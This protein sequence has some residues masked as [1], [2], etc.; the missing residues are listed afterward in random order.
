MW[1]LYF[2][3]EMKT[4]EVQYKGKTVKVNESY[5]IQ[6]LKTELH[7]LEE[8][9]LHA[10]VK[11]MLATKLHCMTSQE[12]CGS[13][14]WE[15]ADKKFPIR[16]H[17][18]GQPARNLIYNYIPRQNYNN[19]V[20]EEKDF[21]LETSSGGRLYIKPDVCIFHFKPLSIFEIIVTS[22]P[23]I[24]KLI[25]MIEAPVNVVFIYAEDVIGDLSRKF[26]IHTDW[27]NLFKCFTGWRAEDSLI[28]KVSRTVD[29]LIADKFPANGQ[30]ILGKKIKKNGD[31]YK[32]LIKTDRRDWHL[33][34]GSKAGKP[35]SPLNAL[36]KCYAEKMDASTEEVHYDDNAMT[37]KFVAR[38]TYHNY[39]D[40]FH[41]GT[42][43]EAFQGE[44]TLFTNREAGIVNKTNYRNIK[45]G[46]E[47]QF[48]CGTGN[49][50]KNGY[51][52]Y[53]AN[54]HVSEKNNF[55]KIRENYFNK[56]WVLE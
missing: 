18:S 28:T 42:I 22:K 48:I 12:L 43:L 38:D 25:A 31:L 14:T 56:V 5:P 32:L 34:P 26:N 10:Q 35:T 29:M 20:Y 7:N 49:Y 54:Y 16:D 2:K 1:I 27:G 33:H 45:E 23:K 6:E 13:E 30:K 46:E 51:Y 36:L 50:G 52:K 15:E 21:P 47:V 9:P 4:I 41:V 39:E 40:P 53:Y 55:D 3:P 8:T 24:D 11:K 37:V 17:L 19:K 44:K